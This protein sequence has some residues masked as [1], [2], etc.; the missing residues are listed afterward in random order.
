MAAVIR[1]AL[2]RELL[3]LPSRQMWVDYDHEADVLYISFRKPQQAD[4]TVMGEDGHLYHYAGGILVGV[5][6]LNASRRGMMNDILTT[7]E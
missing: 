5:T 7:G 4:D 3:R 6:V 2:I 1:D